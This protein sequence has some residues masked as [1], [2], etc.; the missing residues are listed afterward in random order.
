MIFCAEK[1]TACYGFPAKC[2]FCNGIR[3]DA[4]WL[5]LFLSVVDKKVQTFIQILYKIE[6]RKLNK[7]S[8][9]LHLYVQNLLQEVNK[10]SSSLQTVQIHQFI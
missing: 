4:S 6:H 2:K 5:H 7:I 8:K 3:R 1:F 10:I 9:L